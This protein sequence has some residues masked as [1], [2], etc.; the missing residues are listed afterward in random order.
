MRFNTE[1]L[2]SLLI[3]ILL[4]GISTAKPKPRN[5]GV[6]QR[7]GSGYCRESCE[8]KYRLTG[9]VE[10]D[11]GYCCCREGSLYTCT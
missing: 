2:L 4:F 7:C 5:P 8:E 9:G 1:L 10:C 3:T 11:T 6:G